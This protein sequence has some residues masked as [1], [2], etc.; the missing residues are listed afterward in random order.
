MLH[1]PTP[2]EPPKLSACFNL[3][4]IDSDFNLHELQE[5]AL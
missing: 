1:A 4:R 2:Q 3:R 5:N